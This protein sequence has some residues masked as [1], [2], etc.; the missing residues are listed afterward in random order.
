M[1]IG[2]VNAEDAMD[3]L[4]EARA[5]IGREISAIGALSERLDG[6][7]EEAVRL[8][9]GTLDAGGR[10][11]VVGVGK[12]GNVGRKLAATFNSTGAPCVLL[13]AQDALHGDL[14]VVRPG[15]VVIAMSASGETRELLD[16]LPHLKSVPARIIGITGGLKSSLARTS[17]VVLDA[18]VEREA[19]PLDLAPTSS[20]TVMLVLGDAL[21]MVLLTARGFEAADFARLHP[22]GSLGRALLLRVSDVMRGEAS[23]PTAGPD[24]LISDVLARMTELRCGAAAVCDPNQKLL[25]VFTHGDFVRAY[26]KNAEVGGAPVGAHMTADPVSIAPDKLAAEIRT[27]LKERPV[28]DVVVVDAEGR[29][30]GLVDTVDLGRLGI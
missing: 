7:F 28:D 5:V 23:Y 11:L 24:D 25:G 12:S 19:C 27:L 26:R 1:P 15:D 10:L 30:C 16:L 21:A 3:Y 6:S 9:Q 4:E 8:L 13:N 29:A 20:T 18:G 14:G 2:K 17:D 22:G